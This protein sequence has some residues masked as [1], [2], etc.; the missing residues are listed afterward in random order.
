MTVGNRIKQRRLE[1]GLT[2]S[3]LAEKMGYRGKTAVCMAENRGDNITTTKVEK[4]AK[5][6]GVSARWLMGYDSNLEAQVEIVDED[7]VRREQERQLMEHMYRMYQRATPEV[8]SAV[9]LL[10]KSGQRKK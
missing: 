3:E 6:L 10:L 1:L 4:F 2:Q 9:D 8:Q 7:I 5:A